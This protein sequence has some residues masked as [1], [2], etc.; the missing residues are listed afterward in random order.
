MAKTLVCPNCASE[1][2]LFS[3]KRQVHLCEDCEH[4]FAPAFKIKK[5]RLFLSYGHDQHVSLAI[6]LRGD[7]EARGHDVWFDENRLKPGHDWEHS[8][9][10][11]IMHLAADKANAA[12]LLLL[13][14]HAVRRPDG[15]CLN[16]VAYALGRGLRIVPIMVE[17]SEPPLSI[18]RIQWLDMRLCI[19][20]NEKEAYYVPR[21]ARL[22][23]AIED[24]KLDF[25]GAQQS[26]IRALQPLDFDADLLRHLDRFV[27]R[28]WV[29]DALDQWLADQS[30][31]QR[32]FWITGSPGVGKTALS[33]VIANRYLEVA[34]LHLCKAGHSQK[35]SPRSVVTSLAYQL[36][37]QLPDYEAALSRLD[38]GRLVLDDARTLFENIVIQPLIRIPVPDRTFVLLIDA[39]DEAGRHGRNELASFIASEFHKTPSWLRLIITSRPEQPVT[40]PLQALTPFVFDTGT[41]CN[42][43][44]LRKY[45][46]RELCSFLKKRPDQLA[47][48][49][50]L[51]TRSEGL[52]L[53]VEQVCQEV[54][55]GHLTFHSLDSVPLGMGGVFWQFFERQFPEIESFKT[56]TRPALRSILAAREP[57]PVS[58]LQN[59]FGWAEEELRDFIRDLGSLFAISEVNGIVCIRAYHK[60]ISDWLSN[61]TLAGVYYVSVIEGQRHLAD[62]CWQQ[63]QSGVGGMSLYAI[64]HLPAHLVEAGRLSEAGI[65]LADLSYAATKC[66]MGLGYDLWE[67]YGRAL[68][69]SQADSGQVAELSDAATMNNRVDGDIARKRLN[70]FSA[71]FSAQRHILLTEPDSCLEIARNHALSGPVVEAAEACLQERGTPWLAREPRPKELPGDSAYVGC[72][73]EHA[74]WVSCVTISRSGEIAVSAGAD[75]T[76]KVW[77]LKRRRLVKSLNGHSQTIQTVALSDDLRLAV[78]GS[79]RGT[80]RVWDLCVGECIA[81]LTGHENVITG[82]ALL[83]AERQAI[84]VSWDKT[85]RK[86]DLAARRCSSLSNI[87]NGPI[88][89]LSMSGDR[90]SFVTGASDGQIVLW[91]TQLLE[92][93]NQIHI[94]KQAIEAVALNCSGSAVVFGTRSGELSV[95]RTESEQVYGTTRAHQGPVTSVALSDTDELVISS[96]QDGSIGSRDSRTLYAVEQFST[97]S[98][99][100]NS[101]AIA[102]RTVVSGG[103]DRGVKLWNVGATAYSDGLEGHDGPVIS[104]AVSKDGATAISGGDDGTIR[105]WCVHT[106]RCIGVWKG[107]IGK[108][109][110]VTFCP[111]GAFAYSGGRDGSI[112]IWDVV[113][114]GEVSRIE[115]ETRSI[116]GIKAVASD[117]T[118]MLLVTGKK[119]GSLTVWNLAD[120]RPAVEV[121]NASGP[122]WCVCFG[123]DSRQVIAGSLDKRIRV[124]NVDRRECSTELSS[125]EGE[126][127]A[128]DQIKAEHLLVSGASDGLL[129]LWDLQTRHCQVL[130]GHAD[131]IRGVATIK[132]GHCLVSGSIDRTVR[133]WE[134]TTGCCLAKYC[135]TS[136]VTSLAA[137]QDGSSIVCGTCDG[138]LHFLNLVY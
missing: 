102:N 131:A 59:R 23:Q 2:V 91:D 105:R 136:P 125:E 32:V 5:K 13:T 101:I 118:G 65:V 31:E 53:Y 58:L 92:P 79:W 133:V 121:R 104:I 124:W 94:R 109:N 95:W 93:L 66:R 71:F 15:Y 73:G 10:Q 84:T 51:L 49:D 43:D 88:T 82:V 1:N 17:I 130:R 97:N 9:E 37:T 68:E 114:G 42:R 8:I 63:Y 16:E 41:E 89:C 126:V 7:L 3:K 85:V 38:L 112:R 138:K 30:P 55:R 60:A 110:S 52:F 129:R 54:Q 108:V 27:G 106:G 62:V 39:L 128:I 28:R 100:V 80:L 6:R 134:R 44:D 120:L 70:Q 24:D 14:P 21:F 76:I 122:V 132:S 64:K 99:S 4:Q 72:V 83:P 135:A 56:K 61:E 11:G 45:V 22:V 127:F 29:F 18:C 40:S 34:A 35:S 115:S 81:I 103:F 87:H 57:L 25:E 74:A 50:S 116:G 46:E 111:K 119:D 48:V 77:D 137:N 20:I 113:T 123:Q 26:L 19:P 69:V 78:S 86:W 33:A 67:D 117:E 98:G 12:V 90:Q 75:K 47:V 107:H 96:G 36:S